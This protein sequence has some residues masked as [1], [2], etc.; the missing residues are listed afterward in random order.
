MDALGYARY[1]IRA[2]DLGA[3]VATPMALARPD[4]VVG[5]HLSGT[6]PWL[7][8]D[9]LP[10]DLSPAEQRM[11]ADARAFRRDE[12][13]YALVHSTKPATLSVGMHD[14]PAGM[15]AWIVE[16]HR[17]WSDCGGDVERRFSRDELC[18][19]LT[20]YWV[21]ETFASS[22]RLYYESARHP[23]PTGRLRAPVAMAMLPTD[24]YPTPREWVERSGPVARWTELP[25]GGHFGE[26]EEPA[27]LA[28]DIRAFF[29]ELW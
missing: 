27:L 28:A 19:Q 18:T 15:A 3:G 4:A 24:M 5:L 21:T 13:A 2:S 10:D 20:L 8:L 29:R 6:N 25:R 26:H 23:A 14:S 11:V 22:V 7:D 9:A 12:L 1:G 17:A 16:K